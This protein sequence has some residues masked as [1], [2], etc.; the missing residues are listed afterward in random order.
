MVKEVFQAAR[1]EFC[2]KVEALDRA[3]RD[4]SE[5]ESSVER[6]AEE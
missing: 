6:L 4:A 3:H 1:E 2:T 5:V